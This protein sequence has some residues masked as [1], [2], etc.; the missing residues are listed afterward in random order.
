M[1][2]ASEVPWLIA[3]SKLLTAVVIGRA[4][5]RPP[6]KLFTAEVRD[7]TLESMV[8]MSLRMVPV[9]AVTKRRMFLMATMLDSG[10]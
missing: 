2:C 10:K 7:L 3:F 9:A 8:E 4:A 6:L 5:K 1:A